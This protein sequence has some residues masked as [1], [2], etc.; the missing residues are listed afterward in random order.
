M[1]LFANLSQ[2]PVQ[3]LAAFLYLLSRSVAGEIREGEQAVIYQRPVK[4]IMGVSRA[5]DEV[6]SNRPACD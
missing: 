3:K 5:Q 1:D 6:D 4:E 2:H